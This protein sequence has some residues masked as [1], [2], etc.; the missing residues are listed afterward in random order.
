MSK[1]S[2]FREGASIFEEA[3]GAIARDAVK[4][5]KFEL[6][7]IDDAFKIAENNI[8]LDQGFLKIGDVPVSEFHLKIKSGD[9]DAMLKDLDTNV[10]ATASEREAF[11]KTVELNPDKEFKQ[12]DEEITKNKATH[13]DL[14]VAD[15]TKMSTETKEKIKKAESKLKTGA[16]YALIIGGIIGGIG[17]LKSAVKKRDGCWMVSTING[18]TTSCKVQSYSCAS[19][20]T[21]SDSACQELAYTNSVLQ[22]MA[23]SALD[24]NDSIKTKFLADS[25]LTADDIKSESLGAIL[26][27]KTKSANYIKGIKAMA[28]PLKVDICKISN[29]SI[30]GGVIP[31]CRMC[32]IGASP[33]STAYIDP[34]QFASNIS[35]KCVTGSTYLDVLTDVAKS[36]GL[37]LLGSSSNMSGNLGSIFKWGAIIVIIILV[38]L[39]VFKFI[40]GRKQ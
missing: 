40:G 5:F 11:G 9:L 27:D 8:V 10:V 18:Q 12:L 2:I 3:E 20:S 37:D 29:S 21:D 30:E 28:S 35:F 34:T 39:I 23:I 32:D 6:P 25:G 15:E 17:W 22:L 24:D 7:V 1:Y 36:T 13:G 31:A 4:S 33:T 16:K 38:L 19:S 26:T 14:A